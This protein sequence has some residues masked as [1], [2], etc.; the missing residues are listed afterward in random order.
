MAKGVLKWYEK[1]VSVKWSIVLPNELLLG[2]NNFNPF[3]K[4]C[5]KEKW[6]CR[7]GTSRTWDFGCFSNGLFNLFQHMKK[8]FAGEN[9]I[10]VSLR[11]CDNL[12]TD[13]PDEVIKR[14][15]KIPETSHQLQVEDNCI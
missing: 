15:S 12:Y 8:P 3:L 14:K 1:G 7:K 9:E 2:E 11:S 5:Y 6:I 10:G 13:N 4:R